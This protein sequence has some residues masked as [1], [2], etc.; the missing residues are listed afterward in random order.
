ALRTMGEFQSLDDIK[1]IWI[2]TGN[3]RLV[4]LGAVATV[5]ETSRDN[6]SLTRHEGRPSLGLSILKESGANT[7]S[8]SNRV[9]AEMNR[10]EGE[11]PPGVTMSVV[12][13]QAEYIMDSIRNVVSN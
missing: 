3:G 9:K 8:I 13:D 4:T 7:V 1:N 11:L 5:E 10:L 2:P 12:F 6:N